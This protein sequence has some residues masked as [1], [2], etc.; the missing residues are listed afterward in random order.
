M[1]VGVVGK[2]TGGEEKLKNSHLVSVLQDLSTMTTWFG[3]QHYFGGF[4]LF[5]SLTAEMPSVVL[6]YPTPGP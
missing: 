1:G 2:G 6:T 4:S 3:L 5:Y